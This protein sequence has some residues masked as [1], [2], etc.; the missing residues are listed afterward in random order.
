MN[1]GYGNKD[2]S[3][4]HTEDGVCTL[5]GQRRIKFEHDEGEW[6][7]GAWA[8]IRL[9][10][11]GYR[12]QGY[13]A[14]GYCACARTCTPCMS[15]PRAATSVASRNP[16]WPL[17]KRS[18]A[19]SRAAW[20]IAPCSSAAQVQGQQGQ[21]GGGGDGGGC[22]DSSSSSSGHIHSQFPCTALQQ[23]H[24]TGMTRK[25]APPVS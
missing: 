2:W 3:G 25:A 12:V 5:Q 8:G 6:L 22:D 7:Y 13:C 23:M 14:Q 21:S 4:S 16:A 17:L 24:M 9:G 11:Q 19:S 20:L 10:M 18:S 1:Q 15:R